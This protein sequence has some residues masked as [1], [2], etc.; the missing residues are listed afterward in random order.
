M[1]KIT[2]LSNEAY[3]ASIKPKLLKIAAEATEDFLQASKSENFNLREYAQKERYYLSSA[4]LEGT[5]LGE[6]GSSLKLLVHKFKNKSI[7]AV[8]KKGKVLGAK[9]YLADKKSIMS[10]LEKLCKKGKIKEEEVKFAK[11]QLKWA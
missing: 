2:P 11:D 7:F 3:I 6:K 4:R 1:T 9:G 10:V 5:T 8:V